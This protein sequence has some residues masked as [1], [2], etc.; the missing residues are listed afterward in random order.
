MRYDFDLIVVGSG[1]GGGTLAQACSRAG[2]RV[3]LIERGAPRSVGGPNERDERATLID[4]RPYDDRAIDVNGVR[5][6][7]YMGGT[8]GGGTS[9]YG[10]AM[11]RPHPSDFQ[12][13]RHYGSRIPREIWDWPV[14]YEDMTSHYDAAEALFG[15]AYGR[16]EDCGVLP[17]PSR[18][19]A[20][21]PLPLAPINRRMIEANRARGLSPFPL[22]LAIDSARCLRCD[23]CAGYLCPTGARRSTSQLLDEAMQAGAPLVTLHQSEVEAFERTAAGQIDGVRVRERASGAVTRLRARR[24]ALS[25]GAIGSAVVLLRSGVAHPHLGRNYMFHLSPI[26]VGV[27]ARATGA[28]QTFV[29]QVGFADFYFGTRAHPHKLGLVQ[30]LPAPGPWMLGKASSR[31]VPHAVWR[32][33]RR[34]ML[35]LVGIVED[36]PAPT[37]RVVLRGDQSIAIEHAFGD[38]DVARGRVL[39]KHM[40]QILRRTG[41]IAT[42]PRMVASPEHVAHQCGTIRF[43]RDPRHAVVDR[44]CRLFAHPEVFVVDGSIMP[45]S[46]GVGPSLTIAANALRIA[47]VITR[48][49]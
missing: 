7:L 37:N 12:P 6:R 21:P 49:C 15:V 34:R 42:G 45:T 28:D 35:P 31:H 26:V 22:P 47:D 23:N 13:G 32:F 36:L 24:Y 25:A 38:Y 5:S 39:A 16:D 10:A 2:K 48:E 18:L 41:A 1:A 46:L 33:L 3:L 30:S 40:R 14:A 11:L 9:V 8:V 17:A 29:K 4:K 43:G 44:D 27:F 19:V 20:N